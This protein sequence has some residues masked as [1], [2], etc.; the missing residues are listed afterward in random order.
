M[1]PKRIKPFFR[2]EEQT[3]HGDNHLIE[4]MLTCCNAQDFEVYI[5]G[6]I[7]R[8]MF[9][10]AYLLPNKDDD[11]IVEVHCKKC[12]N[13]I[14][15]FDNKSD[16][17]ERQFNM[18]NERT[19]ARRSFCC[20]KCEHGGFAVR[21]KFEYPDIQE[22]RGLGLTDIDNAFTWIWITLKCNNCQ[23]VYKNFL[24]CET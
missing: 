10:G 13:I 18:Q 17:Y 19:I 20:R 23:A 9:S 7:K 2:I 8:N 1:I 14:S 21:I 6:D 15:L 16:G 24:D 3:T 5:V 11:I 4:G 22:L 12:G